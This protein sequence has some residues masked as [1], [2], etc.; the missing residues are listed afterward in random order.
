MISITNGYS[1]P[2]LIKTYQRE[3]VCRWKLTQG[4]LSQ[5]VHFVWNSD[6]ASFIR[7]LYYNQTKQ[8]PMQR[9]TKL[10]QSVQMSKSSCDA[11]YM[12]RFVSVCFMLLC[13]LKSAHN[14]SI[15][16]EDFVFFS[17]IFFFS[18]VFFQRSFLCKALALN[19]VFQSMCFKRCPLKANISP[20][21][22]IKRTPTKTVYLKWRIELQYKRENI[23][24]DLYFIVKYSQFFFNPRTKS[25]EIWN[26][27][28]TSFIKHVRQ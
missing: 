19:R 21:Q 26:H 16:T 27:I 2:I 15:Q 5:R 22:R 14:S 7:I 9:H 3:I 20:N 1:I 13:Y 18:Y 24:N 10:A 6:S 28:S 17:S 11:A 25:I 4:P 23:F 8:K 12:V